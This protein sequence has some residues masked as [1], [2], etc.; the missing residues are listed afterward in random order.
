MGATPGGLGATSAL[1]LMII[2]LYFVY[3]GYL[4]WQLPVLFLAGVY[5]SALLLPVAV[6][7]GDGRA[8]AMFSPILADSVA[9]SFTYAN[10]HLF[11]GGVFLAAFVLM[12][13]MTSRPITLSGQMVF[14][15]AA[16]VLTIVFRLYTPIAVPACAAVLVVNTL[17][18]PINRL[19]RPRG[20]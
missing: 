12:A 14:A 17:V 11:T 15:L 6:Q 5:V 8:T 13:E 3:R 10:Y 9:A 16:G 4:R 20:G 18:G 19:T 1:A 2:G 7:A